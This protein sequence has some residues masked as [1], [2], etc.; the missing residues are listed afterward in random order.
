MKSVLAALL[1]YPFRPVSVESLVT[2]VWWTD[3]P[4]T[5]NA[6]IRT[7]IYQLRKL[8]TDCGGKETAGLL[9]T[10]GAAYRL[11]V[12]EDQLDYTKFMKLYEQGK[13]LLRAGQPGRAS[14]VLADALLLW[15]G[16]PFADVELGPLLDVEVVRM[17]EQRR[18]A[19]RFRIDADLQNGRHLELVPEL[20]YLVRAEPFDEWL[21]GRLLVALTGSGRRADA[22]R[23]YQ[24]ARRTLREL[25]LTPSVELEDFHTQALKGE[26]SKVCSM[27]GRT[28]FTPTLVHSEHAG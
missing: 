4:R 20:Q 1:L 15:H 13:E 7:Y 25:G 10:E 22:L 24:N 2:E 12:D 18:A 9:I 23:A 3:P 27:A 6:T 28:A 16:K 8:L 21:H 26:S 19:L 14:E 17:E 11:D 5:A